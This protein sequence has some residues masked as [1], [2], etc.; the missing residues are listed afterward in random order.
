MRQARQRPATEDSFFKDTS[1]LALKQAVW[2]VG[3]YV[4][5][6]EQKD[7]ELIIWFG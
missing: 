6:A 7:M 2:G 1:N 5:G 3:G 4:R